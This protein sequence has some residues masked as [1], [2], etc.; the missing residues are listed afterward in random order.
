[1]TEAGYLL[2]KAI[3]LVATVL[4]I[5]VGIFGALRLGYRWSENGRYQQ[6]DWSKTNN[7][8]K[9]LP[10]LDTRTGEIES[11]HWDD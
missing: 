8:I 10:I 3:C 5:A 6:I 7:R 1:M 11:I 9:P 4:C 2:T